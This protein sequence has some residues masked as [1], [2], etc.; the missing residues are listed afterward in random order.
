MNKRA[1]GG[2]LSRAEQ[3]NH[4]TSE[5]LPYAAQLTRLLLKAAGS[6]VTRREGSLLSTLS[7]GR[8][9]VTALAELEGLPQ[10]TMT[11]LI[12]RLERQGLVNR[13]RPLDDARVV[14]VSLTPAGQRVLDD[15]RS[16][17]DGVLR[18]HLAAMPDDQLAAIHDATRA[19]AALVARVQSL[20]VLHG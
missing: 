10:P 3:I 14:L 11:Q 9:R 7:G 1:A 4:V 13:R 6:E 19:I 2:D 8:R 17:C 15:Y 12:K 5:L 20:R 18:T 16:R